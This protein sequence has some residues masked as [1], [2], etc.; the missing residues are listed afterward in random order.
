M[1]L[2]M[3]FFL[4][5]PQKIKF[6]QNIYMTDIF[7]KA[8]FHRIKLACF[9]VDPDGFE[10]GVFLF[11]PQ[12]IKFIH[13]IYRIEFFFRNLTFFV[14]AGFHGIKKACFWLEVTALF[15]FFLCCYF[16]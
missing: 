2:R 12:K 15:I 9:L 10:N 5:P 1:D 16:P 3:D 4:F 11:P 14:K 6:I 7:L 8:A 13:N